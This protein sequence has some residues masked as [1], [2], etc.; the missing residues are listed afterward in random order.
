V[1]F[2]KIRTSTLVIILILFSLLS[3]NQEADVLIGTDWELVFL[4]RKN[5]IEGT[6]TI[7]E[8]AQT[9]LGGQMGCN[10]YGGS[11]DTW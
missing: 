9:Y 3:C 5:L 6:A 8:F 2:G 11:P 4:N 1:N 10:G 7:L